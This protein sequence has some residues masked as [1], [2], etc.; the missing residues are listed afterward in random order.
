MG[1]NLVS[2]YSK[3]QNSISLSTAEAEYIAAGS[4]CAQLIWMKQ[5]LLDYG[6]SSNV[7][8]V[9]CDNTSAINISKNPVQHSRTKRIDIRHHFSR[10]LVEEGQVV[11]EHVSTENR[12][13]NIF[14]KS[15]MRKD[16]SSFVEL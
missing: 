5:M 4:C 15:W 1:T 10:E 16:L 14:T 6:V 9:Y 7:I 12:L 11:L 13:A 2:W 3:K 8:T